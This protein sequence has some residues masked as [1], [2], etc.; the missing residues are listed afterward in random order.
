MRK[1]L[2]V[3]LA[4][5]ALLAASA[6]WCATTPPYDIDTKGSSLARDVI[7]GTG[8]GDSQL[9]IDG[10]FKKLWGYLDPES[11]PGSYAT[12]AAR[13]DAYYTLVQN[14][15]TGTA[16]VVASGTEPVSPADG[17]VWVDLSSD[18][19]T[20]KFWNETTTS[21][22]SLPTL[23]A[24]NTFTG[25]NRIQKPVM[26]VRIRDW[27]WD[28]NDAGYNER[29][30]N[31]MSMV[32]AAGQDTAVWFSFLAEDSSLDYVLRPEAAMSTSVASKQISLNIE[33]YVVTAAGD[34]TPGAATG[35]GEDEL[36]CPAT[37]EQRWTIT[38]ANLK[39]PASDITADGDLVLVKLW[40]DAA[41]IAVSGDRHTGN[42]HLM[43]GWM[44]PTAP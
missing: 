16:L 15:G 41:G 8:D 36:S 40:V 14:A 28:D 35:T 19:P 33:Y 1:H 34:L 32:F 7:K 13:M 24:D 29:L 27:Q 5:A 37:A 26:P 3:A 11:L 31:W 44:V 42:F 30:G 21:W 22:L 4:M 12:L 39:V 6:G 38:G 20:C 2:F 10:L 17:L 23:S 43:T 18:S 9:G 25:K